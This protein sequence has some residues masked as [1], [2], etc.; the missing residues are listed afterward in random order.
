[1]PQMRLFYS[2][3]KKNIT[4]L[5]SKNIKRTSTKLHPV[6]H[7]WY[8]GSPEYSGYSGNPGYSVNMEC[9]YKEI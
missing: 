3:K 9:F 7:S 5:F 6:L 8:S 4:S 2:G 1:M